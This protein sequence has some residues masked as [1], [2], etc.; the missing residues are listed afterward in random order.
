LL[1]D[2]YSSEDSDSDKGCRRTPEKTL[3]TNKDASADRHTEFQ[4]HQL[5][6]DSEV[7]HTD[8]ASARQS[9]QDDVSPGT[10]NIERP[11]DKTDTKRDVKQKQLLP[12]K[13]TVQPVVQNKPLLKR[14]AVKVKDVF[15]EDSDSDVEEMPPEARMKMRNLGKLTPVACGPNSFSKG[16]EGF[17]NRQ[18]QMERDLQRSLS[19]DKL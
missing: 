6:A 13:L 4:E 11:T 2:D 17:T 15:K 16:K 9:S 3:R 12:I 14:P 7:P 8:Y 19:G 18:K 10:D 5:S 1:L